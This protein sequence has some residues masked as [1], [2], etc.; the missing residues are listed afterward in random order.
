[1]LKDIGGKDG[2]TSLIIDMQW[3]LNDTFL[4]I[5]T[6]SNDIALFDSLLYPFNL[7]SMRDTN[8][9]FKKQLK[10]NLG[11]SLT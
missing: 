4:M 7:G 2:D 1:V 10:I 6:K 8:L 3:I 5:V 9:S 11:K